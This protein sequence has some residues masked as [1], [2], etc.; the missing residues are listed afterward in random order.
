MRTALR[1]MSLFSTFLSHWP[2][3][4]NGKNRYLQVVSICYT[5]W[6]TAYDIYLKNLLIIL[7]GFIFI[8]NCLVQCIPLWTGYKWQYKR[9]INTTKY[10]PESIGTTCWVHLHGLQLYI[11]YVFDS[12][13]QQRLR[14]SKRITML[15]WKQLMVCIILLYYI[16]S[17]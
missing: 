15:F 9:N 13:Q 5:N 3:S 12:I 11:V 16:F 6:N 14:K 8:E 7:G 17:P 2:N 10:I 4:M 1:K